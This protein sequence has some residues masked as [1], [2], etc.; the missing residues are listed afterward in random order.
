MNRNQR[1]MSAYNAKKAAEHAQA[2]SFDRK[3][4]LAITGCS[5]MRVVRAVD[6]EDYL[7]GLSRDA[8]RREKE[9]GRALEL[10][11]A[12]L[13]EVALYAAGYRKSDVISAR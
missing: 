4:T 11:G 8:N 7:L 5:S 10:D 6:N 1:R 2:K 3:L 13:P 9:M 12:C